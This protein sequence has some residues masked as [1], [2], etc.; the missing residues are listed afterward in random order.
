MS[1][2]IGVSRLIKK[3]R[4]IVQVTCFIE[5]KIDAFKL[6]QFNQYAKNWGQIIPRCGGELVGYF[7]PYEGS[8]NQAYGIISFD[9][10]ASYEAYRKRLKEDKQAQENFKFA[11]TE[12]FILEETRR[13]LNPVE[14]TYWQ[15]AFDITTEAV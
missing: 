12:R 6:Q 14:S 13:F 3:G 10:L 8:N 4:M 7:L 11:Q 5:Y 1:L 15:Q 9:S 2:L